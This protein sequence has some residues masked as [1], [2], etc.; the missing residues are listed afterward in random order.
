MSASSF[1]R[2]L[3][4]LAIDVGRRRPVTVLLLIAL[5]AAGALALVPRVQVNTDVLS[6]MP[7]GNEIVTVF[8]DT[9]EQFGALDL[10]LV[11][12]EPPD[13]ELL[14]PTLA[15][16]DILAAELRSTDGVEWLEY[17][18]DELVEAVAELVPWAPLYLDESELQGLLDTVASQDALDA[19]A[20]ELAAALRLPT[21]LPR[22]RLRKVDPLGMVTS[23]FDGFDT[24]ALSER[25]DPD[26]GY[27]ID[28]ERRFVLL[29]VKPERPPA[30]VAF[31]RQLVA[32]V[33]A[34]A[35][36]A[37]EVWR[38]EGWEEAV[39]NLVLGGGHAVGVEDARLITGDLK[40]GTLFALIAVVVLFATAFGRLIAMVVAF[41][42]LV[43][44]L[45]LTF[46]FT[47]VT[48]GRLNAVTAA[49]AALLIGLG[50]DF[51]IVIYG[52]YVEE[53]RA[54]A[55]HGHALAACGSHTA[56]SVL[57][58][59]IT[60]A[61]TFFAFLVS[62]FAGLF[63][64]GLLT[65]AGIL[66]VMVTVFLLLPAL[67]TLTERSKERPHKLRG[68]GSEALFLWSHRNPRLVLSVNLVVTLVLGALALGV[69][70]DDDALNMRSTENTGVRA[71]QEVMD[72]FGLRFN[73]YM[74]RIDGESE[75]QAL[76]RARELEPTLRAMID[77]ERVAR[78]ESV[79]PWLPP[80]AEQEKRLAMLRD[81]EPP[82]PV[83][84]ALATALENAGLRPSAFAEGIA[85][86]EQA[87]AL[88]TPQGPS[89]LVDTS[90]GHALGRYVA[91]TDDGF[92][93][94]LYAYPPSGRWRR[95][96]PPDLQTA[97][98]SQPWAA[99]TGGVVVSNELRRVVWRDAALA[100]ILGTLVVF[101]FLAWDLG[102]FRPALLALLPLSVGLVWML[103]LMN[104]ADVAVNFM[105]IFVFTMILGI[106]VDY[107]IHLLHR[108]QESDGDITDV[109]GLAPAIAVAACTTVLGFGS[110]ALSHFPGLVSMGSAA[111]FGVLSV[112]WLGLTLLPALAGLSRD[113]QQRGP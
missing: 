36:R 91:A 86:L 44:G 23:A 112:A 30:D 24:G 68:F 28:A 83:G 17:H 12:L 50:I 9:L 103:G 96:P 110:L 113:A 22:K 85:N 43:V 70:Y 49:F 93:T 56:S 106:G 34:A 98:D 8:S 61:A 64:L 107:G 105:N 40:S 92:A 65:G 63:E 104:L 51:V 66:I 87:L 59:A 25:F 46:G 48:L 31:G 81:F 80:A 20:R 102:G 75:T 94:V 82:Q 42:P 21:D 55:D 1:G 58:G 100:G 78:V 37:T 101:L 33:H 45:A 6:L 99:L 13:P 38:T 3:E 29:L 90:L 27:L 84:P 67:L 111:I 11:A 88:D 10:M 7:E 79:L 15:Y 26:T 14:D 35:D 95:G 77:G 109:A 41:V 18:R 52:R 72:A 89:D 76:D 62:D 97:V 32:D 47:V 53:R 69:E 4:R 2:G 108:W 73:P 57:L 5:L 16:A 39:P 71:Q 19:S 74:V 60:T 54:G